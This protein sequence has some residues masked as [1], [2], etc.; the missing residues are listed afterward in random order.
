LRLNHVY[1]KGF[2][3]ES[4]VLPN[5]TTDHRPVVTTVGWGITSQRQIN[6]VTRLVGRD[7]QDSNLLSL[8]KAKNDPKVLWGLAD[9]ALEKDRP[10]LPA[11]VT[12]VDGNPTMT[13]L[14]AAKVV[15]R[16][17]VDKV[18]ALR[19]KAL[20]PRVDTPD[21]L[22]EVPQVPREVPDVLWDVPDNLQE[23]R[24]VRQQVDD[25]CRTDVTS[26]NSASNF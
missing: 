24:D 8:K 12:G 3:S 20:L 22:A 15:N 10:S 17:F 19:A 7:K 21:D 16:F 2:I 25:N 14:E 11:S 13:P 9:Q 1:T 5:S 18:D 6:K 26:Q 23:V 4:V